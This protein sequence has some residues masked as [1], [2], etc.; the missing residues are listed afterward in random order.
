MYRAKHL[1]RKRSLAAPAADRWAGLS[2]IKSLLSILS[3]GSVGRILSIGSA[4][5]VTSI[6]SA[7]RSGA[8][9]APVRSWVSAPPEAFSIL[10][11][12]APSC[13]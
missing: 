7:A 9:A 2:N 4:G 6:G 11:A 12:S 10:A 13:G 8:S 1:R 3:I 5:S